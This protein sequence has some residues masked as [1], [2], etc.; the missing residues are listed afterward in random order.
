MSRVTIKG[1]FETGFTGDNYP[2]NLTV[3]TNSA[4]AVVDFT[5]AMGTQGYV[6][7]I[8]V[9]G[10]TELD[11][12]ATALGVGGTG[13]PYAGTLSDMDYLII[14]DITA[15]SS[16]GFVAYRVL[17]Y[18][19]ID[20][21]TAKV[22]IE[23]DPWLT[24]MQNT[25]PGTSNTASIEVL[26]GITERVT[27]HP[28]QSATLADIPV[29]EDPLLVPA[30]PLTLAFAGNVRPDLGTGESDGYYTILESALNLGLM[31]KNYLDGNTG[32]AYLYET[33]TGEQV[34]VPMPE[35]ITKN[36]ETTARIIREDDY[37]LPTKT[38]GT[39]YWSLSNNNVKKGLEVANSLGLTDA[40]VSSFQLPFRYGTAVTSSDGLGR[41]EYIS[42][43]WKDLGFESSFTPTTDFSFDYDNGG[44]Y[45]N[46]RIMLGSMNKYVLKATSSGESIEFNPEELL[47]NNASYPTPIV[48]TDPRSD[49]K[50]YFRWKRVK[51]I[52]GLTATLAEFMMYAIKGLPWQNAPQVY[53]QKSGSAIDNLNY[54]V[55]K[56]ISNAMFDVSQSNAFKNFKNVAM[57]GLN[58]AINGGRPATNWNGHGSFTK[59]PSFYAFNQEILQNASQ[60]INRDKDFAIS[61]KIVSPRVTFPINQTMRDYMGETV[62]PY[63]VKPVHEDL[64]RMDKLL[65]MYG[66]RWTRALQASDFTQGTNFAYVKAHNV[67]IRYDGSGTSVLKIYQASS[68]LSDQVSAL[69]DGG[70]RIWKVKPDYS[71]YSQAN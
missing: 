71:Y 34:S 18:R 49:G 5:V 13:R 11:L 9:D 19:M 31:G 62:I 16:V 2:L 53:T 66:I 26:D 32:V 55:D 38:P 8:Q 1:Y 23:K 22:F 20:N 37:T 59:D 45:H 28:S 57:G 69:L 12:L 29:E 21:A 48:L 25:G 50:V 6:E 47:G 51:R 68:R 43:F 44:N 67:K 24:L 39:A 58:S 15:G 56:D 14:D 63:R 4:K 70:V 33:T 42:G 61:Q 27:Y 64:V 54:Q 60:N 10:L 52:N 65:T 46:K 36:D 30:H 35:Y 3:L 7:L 17:G 41:V 40:I